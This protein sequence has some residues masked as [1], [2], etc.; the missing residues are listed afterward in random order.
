MPDLYL[1]VSADCSTAMPTVYCDTTAGRILAIFD[2]VQYYRAS[3]ICALMSLDF[4]GNGNTQN[5]ERA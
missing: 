2:L 4:R 3:I 5:S 1:S